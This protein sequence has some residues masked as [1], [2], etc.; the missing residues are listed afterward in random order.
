MYWN[1]YELSVAHDD[2]TNVAD[3]HLAP[4]LSKFEAFCV[5]AGVEEEDYSDPIVNDVTLVSD[6][7]DSDEES[8]T[9]AEEELE[10]DEDDD[11]K[12][13]LTR[14][15]DPI[16]GFSLAPNTI[17]ADQTPAMIEDKEEH[18][19]T[20]LAA[21]MLRYHYKFNHASFKKL[22]IWPNMASFHTDW[23]NVIPQYAQL[24]CT[25]KQLEGHGGLDRQQIRMRH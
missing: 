10:E 21:E 19:P 15:E 6:G 14:S 2:G 24:A 13:I 18:Q 20:S 22:R 17:G 3:I 25:A 1:G 8:M 23:R 4:G 5:E 9:E 16:T 11:D 7:K 12:D